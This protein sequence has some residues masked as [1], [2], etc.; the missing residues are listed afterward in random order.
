MKISDSTSISMPMRNLISIV[1]AVAVGVWAYFGVIERLNKL[2]TQSVLL[3]KDMTAEDER[4]HNE[5]TKNT[6]FR[7]R[8]PRGE[9]GQSSQDIEQFM[10]IEDLYKSVDRMQKH[11]DDMA[12]NKVNIEF[13]KEQMEKA[14]RSIE[15]LKDAD[16]EIV[17]KNGNGH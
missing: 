4:L 9:L 5:V 11:L 7:I 15:K 17:Y 10:L 2:E 3:E 6:D 16:R 12:N 1:A 13:L 8:Y 14:L